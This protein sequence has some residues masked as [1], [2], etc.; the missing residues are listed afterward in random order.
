MFASLP[1]TLVSFSS[2]KVRFD[3]PGLAR[4][5]SLMSASIKLVSENVVLSARAGGLEKTNTKSLRPL[6]TAN[7]Q[8]R[9]IRIATT[10]NVAAR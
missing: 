8:L 1:G 6:H 7:L 2:G 4:P 5:Q 10:A 9:I 3:K